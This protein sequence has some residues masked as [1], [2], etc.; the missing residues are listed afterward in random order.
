[1]SF[2]PLII[3][4]LIFYFLIFRPQQKKQ[5]ELEKMVKDLQKNDQVVTTSGIHGTVVMLKD[6][7]VVLRVDDGVRIEFSR[8]AVAL[9]KTNTMQNQNK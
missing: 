1:M 5:K 3:I 4:F 8:D 6:D 7:T 9:K 2:F